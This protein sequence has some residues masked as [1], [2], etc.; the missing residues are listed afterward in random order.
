MQPA[1]MHIVHHGLIPTLWLLWAAVWTVSAFRAKRIVRAESLASR[2]SHIVPL[3]LSVALL[4]SP[5]FAGPLLS[6]HL[7]SQTE[8]TYWSGA[9]L[10][11]LGL[12]FAVWARAH[13]AG[14]WSGTVTPKQDHTLT[15]SGPYRLARHPIYTGILLAILGTAIAMAEWRGYLALALTTAAFRR[16]I[17]IEESFLTAQFG[18]AYTSYRAE[19]PTLIPNVAR[20]R[21]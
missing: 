4:T 10:V 9:T 7:Y 5:H 11:A 1:P 6:T 20:R 21:R 2:L 17:S 8:W 3:F 13:L 14:N 15:R 16:K 19:V 12:A 18:D